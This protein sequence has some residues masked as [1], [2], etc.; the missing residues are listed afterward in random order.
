M[1]RVLRLLLIA[2]IT[3]GL[4][5]PVLAQP[6]PASAPVPTAVGQPPRVMI[7]AANPLAVEAG[8]SVLRRGGSAIDAAVAVQA[9]LG[10]VEPQSSGIGGGSYMVYYDAR[11]RAV[12]AY[13]GREFAPAGATPD[14]FLGADGRPLPFVTALLSG[15]STGVPGAVAMLALAQRQHGRLPWNGLFTDAVRLADE[16]FTVSPRLAG[17][18]NSR[19]P[20]A[21]APDAVAY[22]S[23]P[24]GGGRLQAGDRLR[25]PAYA[26]TLRRLAA[27]GP[28]AMYRGQIARDIVAR[29]HQG[30]LPGSMTLAD[31]AAYRPLSGP[32]L[33]R[34]YRI[35]RVCTNRPASSGVALLQAL[36]MLEHTDINRRG[37][38]DPVAWVQIAEA[39]RLMYADRDYYVGD[40]AFTPVPLQAMLNP[41]YVAQRARLIGERA[42]PAPTPGDL[43]RARALGP[44]NTNEVGGTSHFVVVDAAGNVVSMTTTVESIFGSG[45]MVH[46]FFLNNQLTDFSFAPTNPNGRPAANA[47]G[48]RKRPRSSMSPVIVLDR[49][50]RFVAAL[51]SPGGNSILSY[52]LRALVG[53]LDWNLSMQDSFALP[54]LVARGSTFSSEPDRYPP[55]VVA[56]LAERGIVFRDSAGENSGLHGVQMTPHGLA[57]GADPRREG[58]ARGF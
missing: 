8:L 29:L 55:G 42:G 14:M 24:N 33:C 10:L 4:Q 6:R 56:A 58:V 43:P 22:F 52:N 51:G 11:T 50:G 46:G 37:P 40:P 7:A 2:A 18:I 41:A 45:R 12:T 15:R 54:N 39:E 34:P 20:Q 28:S 31:L 53:V 19:F 36:G 25:N 32:A 49:Q 5:P 13:D 23:R 47:V 3:L 44:D 27:E 26:A 16:G 57:G 21:N 30:D 35:W 9:V 38:A 48:P 1:R 17:M